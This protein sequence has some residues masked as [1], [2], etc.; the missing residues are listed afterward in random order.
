MIVAGGTYRERV[1][2]TGY[3]VDLGGS[4]FR[5]ALAAPSTSHL[6]T[7]VE[8]DLAPT[9]LSAAKTFSL[10][11][12]NVG[13]DQSVEFTY[14]SAFLEPSLQGRSARF[15]QTVAVHGD[16]GLVFGVVENGPLAIDIAHLVY[17]PQSTDDPALRVLAEATYDRGVMCANVQEVDAIGAGAT[18]EESAQAIRTA[19]G[20]EAVIV[21]AGARGC[22]VVDGSRTEWVGAVPSP[23]VRKVGS[24]DIFSASFAHAWTSGAD[25]V[26]AAR[27]ASHATS[28]WVR[29][30]VD[31]IPEDVLASGY[32]DSSGFAELAN[33]GRSPKIYLAGPF[34]SAAEYWLVSQ[35]RIF[36]QHAGADVFSPVHDVGLG[37]TEVALKDLEGFAPADAVFAIL[38]GWDPG[39]LFETGWAHHAS[40]PVVAAGSRLDSIN[41][42]MLAGTGTEL[43]TDFTTA[44]YRAIW[45]GLGVETN[46]APR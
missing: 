34:F 9:L 36:L 33:A 5:A 28:W 11:V 26:E 6:V 16:A 32:R 27:I 22:L 4:A 21:K 29:S 20:L 8:P 1:I 3:D 44:M 43:Y 10:D 17:D 7:A 39:T 37:G 35:C 14:L 13:R 2:T 12:D 41:T 40:I 15:D 19:A 31:R 45:R 42:T 38:D 24:G 18:L 23:T 25:V 30:E 46:G